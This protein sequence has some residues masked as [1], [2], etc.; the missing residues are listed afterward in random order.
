[1]KKIQKTRS[2]NNQFNEKKSEIVSYCSSNLK[3]KKR[4]KDNL[5]CYW[6]NTL[7]FIELV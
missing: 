1:M 4:N 3:N 7:I 6:T 2:A 5:E